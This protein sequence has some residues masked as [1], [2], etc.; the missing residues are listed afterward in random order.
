MSTYLIYPAFGLRGHDYIRQDFIAGNIILKVQPKDDLI[1]CPCCHCKTLFAF[2][3]P[4]P[5]P[6]KT[7]HRNG[8]KKLAPPLFSLYQ[9][10]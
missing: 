8:S 9:H 6:G 10:A 1:R 7:G 5:D 4:L 2:H 3:F